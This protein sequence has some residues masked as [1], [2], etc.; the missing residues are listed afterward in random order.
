MY[1][2]E[3][4]WSG[5]KTLCNR[6]GTFAWG[7]GRQNVREGTFA[8]GDGGQNV[9]EGTFA[10]ERSPRATGERTFARERSRRATG[11]ENVRE[12]TFAKGDG[13]QN[14]REGMFAKGDL[15]GHRKLF[16]RPFLPSPLSPRPY[17][18]GLGT[19]LMRTDD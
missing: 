18:K 12:G 10:R 2:C 17:R 13:G 9:R 15:Q 11:G 14:V 1:L 8:K 3:S 7:D 19:K 6:E 5:T 16:T 4:A